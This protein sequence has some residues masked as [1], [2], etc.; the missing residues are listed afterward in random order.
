VGVNIEPLSGESFEA[1]ATVQAWPGLRTMS[2]ASD[3]AHIRRSGDCV[4]DGDDALALLVNMGGAMAISQSGRDVSLE[5]GGSTFVLHAEPSTVIHSQVNFQGLIVPR[6][7]LAP[8][9]TNV[10]DAAAR[11]VRRQNAALRLLVAYLNI[12]REDP[13]LGGPELHHLI[14]THVHDLVATIMGTHRDGAEIAERGVRAARLAT[15]KSDI[16]AH[17]G[18][19]SLGV[20]TVAARHKLSRRSLQALFEAAGITFSQFVLEQRLV[21]AHRMLVDTRHADETISAIAL[22]VGFGDIS[23]FNRNFRRRYGAT[24]SELRSG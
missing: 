22:A 3:A 21:R 11:P 7:V 14:A 23:Y 10:E 4:A 15:I 24:P 9:V 5:Q 16:K 20:S 6:S 1:E 8:L 19:R 17:L 13:S 12:M 2:F 18:S